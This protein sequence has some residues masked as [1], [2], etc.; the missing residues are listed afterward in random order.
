MDIEIKR[1]TQLQEGKPESVS[2]LLIGDDG[3]AKAYISVC[4]KF[5]KDSDLFRVEISSGNVSIKPPLKIEF[6]I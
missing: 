6:D 2:L 3:Q 1:G 4:P 5:L